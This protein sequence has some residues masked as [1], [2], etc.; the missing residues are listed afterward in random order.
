MDSQLQKQ[1]EPNTH[2]RSDDSRDKFIE[3]NNKL[4]IS[5]THQWNNLLTALIA[6][7]QAQPSATKLK[8]EANEMK[9]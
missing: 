5:L 9:C 3:T 8:K 7:P 2:L 4:H 6:D 1:K